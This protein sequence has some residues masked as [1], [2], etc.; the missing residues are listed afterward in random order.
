MPLPKRI[1]TAP[2]PA[3]IESVS[4]PVPPSMV[5]EPTDCE[6]A[7]VSAPALMLTLSPALRLF[8]TLSEPSP[9]L[10]VSAPEPSEML[11]SPEPV[12]MLMPTV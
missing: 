9:R 11:S 5:L 6:S 1:V 4:V 7:N 2:A 8:C 10:A 12:V 3:P